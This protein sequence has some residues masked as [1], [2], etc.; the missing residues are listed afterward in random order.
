M[1]CAG[2]GN[3]FQPPKKATRKTRFC[4]PICRNRVYRSESPSYLGKEKRR[5][6]ICGAEFE[7]RKGWPAETCSGRGGA[8]AVKLW[9]QTFEMMRFVRGGCA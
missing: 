8:C 9:R 6:V 4:S 7:T 5:C 1:K 3:E 2:C